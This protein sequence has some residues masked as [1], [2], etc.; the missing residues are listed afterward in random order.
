MDSADIRLKCD[1]ITIFVRPLPNIKYFYGSTHI[2]G[3]EQI[4]RQDNSVFMHCFF[5]PRETILWDILVFYMKEKKFKLPLLFSMW[6][7]MYFL[8]I[9]GLMATLTKEKMYRYVV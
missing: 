7:F 4:T 2:S 3:I 5:G 9:F 1:S 8:C 6:Q